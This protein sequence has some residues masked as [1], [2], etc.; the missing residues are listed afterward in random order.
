M[1]QHLSTL[2]WAQSLRFSSIG[3][4]N[5]RELKVVVLVSLMV[6]IN[7]RALFFAFGF[8]VV[9]RSLV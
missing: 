2:N 1:V 6:L 5:R 8:V 7:V 4:G 9:R 3:G